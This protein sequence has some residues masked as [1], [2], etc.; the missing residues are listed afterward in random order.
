LDAVSDPGN[1]GT[2][3]RSAAAVQVAG[4]VCLAGSCNVWNPK[5]VR[6]AMGTTFTVPLYY[7]ETWQECCAF[8]QQQGCVRVYAATMME[9]GSSSSDAPTTSGTLH[10]NVN[11]TSNE[12]TALV[13]GNEGNGLSPNVRQAVEFGGTGSGMEIKAVHVPMLGAVESLNAA[14]CGSVIMFEYLRQIQVRK[15]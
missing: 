12:P 4:V 5:V 11:W 14:V 6:S 1:V 13:I 8:L 3:I 7:H 15:H 9:D 10:Y 2:L